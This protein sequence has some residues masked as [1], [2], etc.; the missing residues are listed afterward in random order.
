[1]KREKLGNLFWDDARGKEIVDRDT[2]VTLK[3]SIGDLDLQNFGEPN[4]GVTG[5]AKAIYLNCKV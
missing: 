2:S 4:Q 3:N 1:M 5:L